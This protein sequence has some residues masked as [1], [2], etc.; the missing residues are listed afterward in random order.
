MFRRPPPRSSFYLAALCCQGWLKGTLVSGAVVLISL[1]EFR[2]QSAGQTRRTL[3]KTGC[4]Q[5]PRRCRSLDM[6]TCEP[7]G[8]PGFGNAATFA[9]PS[10]KFTEWFRLWLTWSRYPVAPPMLSYRQSVSCVITGTN[11]PRPLGFECVFA[12]TRS[13]WLLGSLSRLWYFSIKA[14]KC[15]WNQFGFFFFSRFQILDFFPLLMFYSIFFQRLCTW[16]HHGDVFF[17][18]FCYSHVCSVI[19]ASS[20]LWWRTII[21]S[22]ATKAPFFSV[23]MVVERNG[24]EWKKKKLSSSLLL[25]TCLGRIVLLSPNN[26]VTA[27]V[28]FNPF[29]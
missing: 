20:L 24:V 15:W 11:E 18:V 17:S 19:T 12:L 7:D 6:S 23:T 2:C 26:S 9:F 22:R 13:L 21:K 1:P 16:N 5:N 4:W 28:L 25:P 10:C 3:D 14:Q 27:I 8:M 29:W